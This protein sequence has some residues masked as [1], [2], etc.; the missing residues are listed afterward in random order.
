MDATGVVN[1]MAPGGQR[2]PELSAIT[3][4]EQESR[5]RRMLRVFAEKIC[6]IS[7]YMKGEGL[8]GS[9]DMELGF[10][11]GSTWVSCHILRI[12]REQK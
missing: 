5:K 7:D 4:L 1:H 6:I 8:E 12:V 9:S 11:F 3:L 10:W 2:M